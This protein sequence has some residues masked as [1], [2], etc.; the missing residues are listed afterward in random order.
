MLTK[1]QQV[2]III[3]DNEVGFYW[4]SDEEIQFFLNRAEDNVDTAAIAAAKS[5]VFK[6]A[7]RGSASVD[8][9]S[10]RGD[11]TAEQYAK[12]LKEFI[13]DPTSNP[14]L[15]SA[16]IWVGGI[17]KSEMQMNDANKNNNIVQQPSKDRDSNSETFNSNFWDFI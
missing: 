16:S 17:D 15:N 14:Y 9:F 11:R 7:Q 5:V 10:I 12:A 3:Q 6:L 1:I 4:L 8:I 2:R 13:K